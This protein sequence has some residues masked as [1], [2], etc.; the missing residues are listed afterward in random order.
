VTIGPAPVLAVL[1]GLLH[2][3]VYVLIRGSTDGRLPLLLLGA[4]LGAWAGDALGARLGWDLLRI[5]DFRT[6]PASLMAW[7]GIA[8]V[9]VVSVLGSS[10][11][12]EE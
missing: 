9:T 8:T 12:K 2:T 1:V 6:L 4:C 10:R 11:V 5:G 7:L 3:S